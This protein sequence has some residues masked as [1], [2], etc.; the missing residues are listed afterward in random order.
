MIML[1]P[2]FFSNN[3]DL[4]NSVDGIDIIKKSLLTARGSELRNSTFVVTN[5]EA[6]F[7]FM[8]S[9]G[10]KTYKTDLGDNEE[11]RNMFFPFGTNTSIN[12][13]KNDLKIKFE[14]I[15]VLNFRNPN[16]TEELINNAITH[17]NEKC[18][19]A[20]ISVKN[21][22]DHPCQLKT[23]YKIRGK[24]FFHLFNNAG[25]QDSAWVYE[26]E[27]S[28]KV[29]VELNKF[30][31]YKDYEMEI[32]AD[33]KDYVIIGASFSSDYKDISSFLIKELSADRYFFF[34]HN[35]DISS[36]FTVLKLIPVKLNEELFSQ[37]FDVNID[38]NS[39]LIQVPFYSNYKDFAGVK[40][41][42]L[43]LAEDDVYDYFEPFPTDGQLWT[44]EV[45]TTRKYNV[46]TKKEII[47]REDF[48]DVYE[49]DGTF[50]IMR[51][52]MMK[53]L[54]E[55]ILRENVD[56]FVIDD[57]NST[58]IETRLDLIKYKA[59]QKSM[60]QNP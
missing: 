6:V 13:L 24:G 49:P 51:K 54:N 18:S 23:C 39:R 35:I 38:N 3:R 37:A 46:T 32:G 12:Y 58:Q 42:L 5:E 53:V 48:P 1:I 2:V 15:I 36:K 45:E 33:N 28:L 17:F 27:K 14:Q 10:M 57:I 8:D 47:G 20:L 7:N 26:D 31:I 59:F 19:L 34:N 55:N 29:I 4:W 41:T 22:S 9:V 56:A 43:N 44:I 11:E 21:S 50:V 52:D 16:V 30:E 40:Y 60:E 25:A